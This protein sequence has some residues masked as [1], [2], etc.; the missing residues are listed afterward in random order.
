MKRIVGI[1]V[2]LGFLIFHLPLAAS[3]LPDEIANFLSKDNVSLNQVSIY[4]TPLK[5]RA[6]LAMHRV[7]TPLKPASVIKLSTTYAALRELGTR[8]RWPTRFYYSGSFHKGIISGDLIV[9]AYGDPTLSYKDIRSIVKRLKRI[10]VRRIRGGLLIDRS[11]FAVG[12]QIHSG[13]DEHRYSEYNAMP[14]ALMFDDHLC[15]IIVDPHSGTPKA[16]KKIP[17]PSFQIINKISV[18]NKACRGRYT[19]PLVRVSE[20]NGIATV[21]LSGTLSKRCLPRPISLVLGHPYRAF[22]AAL[23]QELKAAGITLSS[24]MRLGRVPKG[25]RVLFTHYSRPLI[26][27]V[28]K[29]NK[30]SNNLYAR[31]IFLLLGAKRFGAP[32]T[33]QKARRAVKEILGARGILGKETILDNGC[34]LSRK[35]RTTA[36]AIH[37]LLQDAYR[38]YGWRWLGTLAIAGKEGTVKRRYRNS[39]L[40][41]HAWLKTGTLKG[42]KNI[43]GYVMGHSG[44]LYNVVIFYNGR[45]HWKGKLLQDQILTWLVTKK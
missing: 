14:D 12:E 19:W 26:K 37:R 25:A 10:G 20:G 34:G 30:E 13:F 4:I 38:S 9:K 31:H 1:F 43:A 39:A 8:W 21:K 32:A 44:I 28:A 27:I 5:G 17:Y 3:T 35:S 23:R 18:T 16:Y 11:F 45:E 29:T 41:G 15:R 40:R 42:A 33:L 24:P 2:V 22:D 6:P 7:D 36:R